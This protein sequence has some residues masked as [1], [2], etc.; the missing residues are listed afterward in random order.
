MVSG[1]IG[2]C[3]AVRSLTEPHRGYRWC[4]VHCGEVPAVTGESPQELVAFRFKKSNFVPAAPPRLNSAA[5]HPL[6]TDEFLEATVLPTQRKTTVAAE[7]PTRGSVPRSPQK[8][9]N[10]FRVHP[11]D[12][13]SFPPFIELSADF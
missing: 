12:S 3:E 1:D 6:P 7:R 9:N 10:R 13:A 11:A 4:H 5:Q 8:F 2:V